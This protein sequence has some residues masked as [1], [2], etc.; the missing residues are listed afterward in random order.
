MNRGIKYLIVLTML[1]LL[2]PSCHF[3]KKKEELSKLGSS[4]RGIASV[5]PS[6]VFV[7][8]PAGSFTMGSPVRER[9][10]H[11][12]EKQVLVEI[13]RPFEIMTTEV[14][15]AQYVMVM[16]KNPS[17]FKG[18]K[19]CNNYDSV[20]DMCPDHP[21]EQVSWHGVQAFI[22]KLNQL[23]GLKDCYGR[24]SDRKGCY[25]LPTEAE[26][27]Y[28]AR[29]GTTTAYFFGDM[30][31]IGDYAV[32][33]ENSRRQ[34]QRVGSKSPNPW[35]LYDMSGNVSEWVRDVYTIRLPGEKDPLVTYSYSSRRVFRGGSWD[36][37]PR[38][39]RSADRLGVK[40]SR[41]Y[42]D[43]GFRLVRTL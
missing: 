12:N 39:L 27:E 22:K 7:R 20:K 28:S 24:P 6:F 35:G 33:K 29:A 42:D 25:R 23:K 9:G 1:F 2:F 8:I 18:T 41:R 30:F 14:T 43:V 38:N 16:G 31:Q 21:V 17:A 36:N 26:W 11:S 19:Y 40:R 37:D 15:Q 4:K 34:T 13:S 3:M 10:R 32:Y 5:T